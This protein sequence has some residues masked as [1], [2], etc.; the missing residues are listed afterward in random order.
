M[1]VLECS[2]KKIPAK[3][4]RSSEAKRGRKDEVESSDSSSQC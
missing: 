4:Y 2:G 3:L 1:A